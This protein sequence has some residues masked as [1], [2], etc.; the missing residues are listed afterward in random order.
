M[1]V[2]TAALRSGIGSGQ[3]GCAGAG[4]GVRPCSSEVPASFEVL[5]ECVQVKVAMLAKWGYEGGVGVH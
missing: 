4:R 1:G 2:G 5:A 3:W